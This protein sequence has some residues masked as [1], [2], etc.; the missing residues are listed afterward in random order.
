MWTHTNALLVAV[1]L[2]IA[3][4][5]TTAAPAG[6]APC[7]S[8]LNSTPVTR[9]DFPNLSQFNKEWVA[10]LNSSN[11]RV[12]GWELYRGVVSQV[13]T[14]CPAPLWLSWATQ[15]ELF[16]LPSAPGVQ[17]EILLLPSITLGMEQALQ[18]TVETGIPASLAQPASSKAGDAAV[19]LGGLTLSNLIFVPVL[20]GTTERVFFSTAHFNP[21]AEHS[22]LAQAPAKMQQAYSE[23]RPNEIQDPT[24]ST[25][26][27]VK[28]IW[29]PFVPG[30]QTA[31]LG[32][33][34]P[35]LTKI[36]A[37]KAYGRYPSDQWPEQVKIAVGADQGYCVPPEGSVAKQV[38]VVSVKE[39]FSM[40]ITSQEEGKA[41]NLILPQNTAAAAA[42]RQTGAWVVLV[43]FHVISKEVKSWAW[44][45]YWW[46]PKKY[47][48]GPLSEGR[49]NLAAPWSNYVMNASLDAAT[50]QKVASNG[51]CD[52][53]A[54]YNP[55]QEAALQN[56]D[57]DPQ[58]KICEQQRVLGGLASNCLSCHSLAGYQPPSPPPVTIQPPGDWL[59][60]YFMNKTRTGFLWSIPNSNLQ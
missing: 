24:P 25:A 42:A 22:G 27:I 18:N 10:K 13:A 30:G 39:F 7:A 28:P 5:P 55:Y 48:D 26:I 45:T 32:V 12:H 54:I 37:E 11:V 35:D 58:P 52:V 9:H 40:Q 14:G 19:G 4:R 31:C 23:Q 3:A 15:R 38:P 16:Q 43:G 17:R 21:A 34:N 20:P 59:G 44:N 2:A 33:W 1:A 47:R 51:R 57:T 56:A 36:P 53:G 41:L 6:G 50:I 8:A 46:E 60:M 29:F 49:P